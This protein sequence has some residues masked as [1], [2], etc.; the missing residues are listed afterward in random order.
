MN[1]LPAIFGNI[2]LP[3]QNIPQLKNSN[4]VSRKFHLGKLEDLTRIA[5]LEGKISTSNL[6]KFKANMEAIMELA[7]FGDRLKANMESVE[8]EQRTKRA[9]A[10]QEEAKAKIIET[11][12]KKEEFDFFQYMKRVKD[13][14]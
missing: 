1:N 5:E 13:E 4:F 3:S 9:I 10:R 12:A 14:D 2:A 11:E 8:L 6:G 7:T